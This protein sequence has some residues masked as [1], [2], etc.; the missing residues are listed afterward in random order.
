MPATVAS[1]TLDDVKEYYR[2]IF[3]PDLATIVV[4]G[5]VTP[6]Q[7]QEIIGKYFGDWKTEGPKPETDLPPVPLN[8]PSAA[9]VPDASRV[10]SEVTL[11]QTLGITRSHPDYYTLQVG[12]HVLTG[13]FY[14]TRL[15]R[16]LRER[17]GLVYSVEAWLNVGKTRSLYM[18]SFASDP[19]NV[20]KARTLVERNLRDMQTT[21]VTPTELQ[22]AKTL[23]IRQIPLSRSSTDGIA[24]QF[25][26]LA[27][28]DLPLDEPDR[29]A[30]RFLQAT[31]AQVRVAFERWI[32]PQDF[33]QITL[34][35]N[36][37]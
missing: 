12:N 18:V 24:G 2:K 27:L 23:L 1:L 11:A 20:S 22:Q 3:R 5:Q 21:P 19:P 26:H 35:P 8:K 31:A 6:A 36:P 33:V 28:E 9:V 29:A 37:E 15:Y 13:A 32:R 16:D 4:I 17:A 14:A 30:K 25:L 34:G 10:Q 7:A